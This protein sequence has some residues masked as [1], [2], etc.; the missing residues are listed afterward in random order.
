MRVRVLL[1]V[2]LFCLAAIAPARTPDTLNLRL[3]QQKFVSNGK[4][5]V[6]FLSVVEDSRCP[7]N[8]RCIW[9]GNAKI[10]VSVAKG[11][12]AARI[13][14]LETRSGQDGVTMYGYR[15]TLANLS[16]H[17]GEPERPKTA[18]I[19]IKRDATSTL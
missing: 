9:A 13:I 11:R 18:T 2:I 5:T 10:R 16:P 17:P 7:I 14:E 1:P 8:A 4:L 15:F 3:G 6:K 12:A 19:G